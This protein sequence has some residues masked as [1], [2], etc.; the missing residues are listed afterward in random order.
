MG[1]PE[2]G[3]FCDERGRPYGYRNLYICD[4]SV[5]PGST[6]ISPQGTVMAFAHKI[7]R[8]YLSG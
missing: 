4:G 3:G 5:L 1:R 2:R 7:A 6:G 8:R